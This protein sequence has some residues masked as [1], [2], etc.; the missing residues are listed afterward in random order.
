[1]C[2]VVRHIGNYVIQL[3]TSILYFM[4][5]CRRCNLLSCILYGQSITGLSQRVGWTQASI[6]FPTMAINCCYLLQNSSSRYSICWFLCNFGWL[7]LSY[8]FGRSFHLFCWTVCGGVKSFCLVD[9]MEDSTEYSLNLRWNKTF[10]NSTIAPSNQ[11]YRTL[12]L[13]F[14]N[15]TMAFSS[16]NSLE[17]THKLDSILQHVLFLFLPLSSL[18]CQNNGFVLRV[19]SVFYT[20]LG[21]ASVVWYF[22]RFSH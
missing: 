17:N 22:S 15:R 14:L 6:F 12:K 9:W 4:I 2:W 20:N 11:Y 3:T 16:T 18:R 5:F 21:I 10:A 19:F 7:Y 1:M 13:T 8:S